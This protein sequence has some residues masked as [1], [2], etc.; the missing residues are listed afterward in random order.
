MYEIFSFLN[1]TT[2]EINNEKK[3]ITCNFKRFNGS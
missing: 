3:T 2:A 1:E